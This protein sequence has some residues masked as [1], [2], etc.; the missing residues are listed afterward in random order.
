MANN[1]QKTAKP[2]T[3]RLIGGKW[4]SR[5]LRFPDAEGLR[6]TPDRIRET[7]FNWLGP[8]INDAHC[9]DMFAGS[10]ALGLEALSRGAAYLLAIDNNPLACKALQQHGETL[11]VSRQVFS[12]VNG[13]S[14]QKVAQHSQNWDIVF[15][16]PPF[17]GELLAEAIA[18]LAPVLQ[19][20]TWVYTESD[21][22]V[23]HPPVPSHWLAHRE[24]TA[25]QVRYALFLVE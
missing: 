21:K 1:P 20:D 13:N 23:S 17:N 3:L 16:D 11:G 22:R 18:A 6:P 19:K 7:L 8:Y 25:G 2:N 9:L 5:T 14:L 4:R 12:V 10:G 15:V 24:K